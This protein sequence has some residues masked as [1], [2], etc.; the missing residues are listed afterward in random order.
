MLYFYSIDLWLICRLFCMPLCVSFQG[1]K[2]LCW[3]KRMSSSNV[4]RV[5]RFG[6]EGQLMAIPGWLLNNSERIISLSFAFLI[7]IIR[8]TQWEMRRQISYTGDSNFT[9][10]CV[11]VCNKSEVHSRSGHTICKRGQRFCANVCN[12]TG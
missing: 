1:D 8:R 9:C 12:L 10:Q 2:G 5:E 11:S 3:K 6:G 4:R 7:F